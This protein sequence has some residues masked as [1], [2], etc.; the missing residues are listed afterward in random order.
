MR[1][2]YHISFGFVNSPAMIYFQARIHLPSIH[3]S[4]Q[5]YAERAVGLLKGNLSYPIH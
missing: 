1:G 4:P 5:Y 2:L 3:R